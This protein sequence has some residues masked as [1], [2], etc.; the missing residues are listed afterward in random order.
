MIN[1]LK[2][3]K[4]LIGG[5]IALAMLVT[6]FA[7]FEEP[8][9]ASPSSIQVVTSSAG[10]TTPIYLVTT[11]IAT[12]T[13]QFDSGNVYSTTKPMNMLQVDSISLM[14][15]FNASTSASILRWQYQWSN[16]NID[17]YGLNTA[18]STTATS[19][20]AVTAP[21]VNALHERLV[22]D[23]GGGT[24]GAYYIEADLKSNPS[25]P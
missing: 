4:F 22:L 12:S 15:Y 24:S 21:V 8:A 5:A 6:L 9:F 19:S 23:T 2:G 14:I 10:T 11:G 16:N 1:V 3:N 17:W 25:N 20:I 7:V 18:S 13:F